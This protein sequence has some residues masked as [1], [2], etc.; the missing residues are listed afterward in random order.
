M[1]LLIAHQRPYEGALG[2]RSVER[3]SKRR[4]TMTPAQR[5]DEIIRMIDE[6]LEVE[7][8]VGVAPLGVLRTPVRQNGQLT[9]SRAALRA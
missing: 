7:G 2:K 6:V 1:A 3:L 5:C 4:A 9:P 8:D